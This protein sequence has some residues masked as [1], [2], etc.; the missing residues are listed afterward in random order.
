MLV[1]IQFHTYHTCWYGTI[2][3]KLVYIIL[4]FFIYNEPF[5]YRVEAV[6]I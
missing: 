1:S 5:I 2:N 4:S 6:N 3:L